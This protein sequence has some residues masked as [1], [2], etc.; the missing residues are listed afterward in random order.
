MMGILL[1][2]TRIGS[3]AVNHDIYCMEKNQKFSVTEKSCSYTQKFIYHQIYYGGYNL[4]SRTFIL[5]K[6]S[7]AAIKL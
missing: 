1:H 5:T 2:I 6:A 3:A 7:R 4:M